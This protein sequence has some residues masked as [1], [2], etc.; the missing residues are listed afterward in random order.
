VWDPE[1][2]EW[3]NSVYIREMPAEEFVERMIPWLEAAGM[4]TADDLAA[5]KEWFLRL[6]P[7]VA[8]RV[9]RMDEIAEKVAF[10]FSDIVIDSAARTKVL[11]K[12]G[13][14]ETLIA[15]RKSLEDVSWNAGDIEETLRDMPGEL[16]VKP[17][18]V[19]QAIRVA[20]TGSTVSLPLFES[21]ELLGRE[22]T[23]ERLD[24]AQTRP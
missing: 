23:L 2:L 24:S 9:K 22:Q 14:E 12:E 3:M 13:A 1:K 6:V 11:D 7:L 8:E 19:F 10:L 18:I 21:L 20:I 17:K 5:R 4:G 15:A 16:G